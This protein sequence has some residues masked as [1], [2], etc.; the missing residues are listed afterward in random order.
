MNTETPNILLFLKIWRTTG[1]ILGDATETLSGPKLESDTEISDGAVRDR[2]YYIRDFINISEVKYRFEQ[3]FSQ[4]AATPINVLL[5]NSQKVRP[6]LDIYGQY[7]TFGAPGGIFSDIYDEDYYYELRLY[8]KQSWVN[9][10]HPLADSSTI[11]ADTF[12]STIFVDVES[13]DGRVVSSVPENYLAIWGGFIDGNTFEVQ[14]LKSTVSFTARPYSWMLTQYEFDALRYQSRSISEILYRLPVAERIGEGGLFD[15]DFSPEEN[16]ILR[17]Y[18]IPS[19]YTPYSVVVDGT[20][21]AFWPQDVETFSDRYVV[22]T[23]EGTFIGRP[24]ELGTGFSDYDGVSITYPAPPLQPMDQ[25]FKDLKRA[26]AAWS[27]FGIVEKLPPYKPN[28]LYEPDDSARC[29]SIDAKVLWTRRDEDSANV[30]VAV[31][32]Q[33]TQEGEAFYSEANWSGDGYVEDLSSRALIFRRTNFVNISPGE[34]AWA[35]RKYAVISEGVLGLDS[36]EHIISNPNSNV[37]LNQFRRTPR[38]YES[39][40]CTVNILQLYRNR[41]DGVISETDIGREEIAYLG[42]IKDDVQGDLYFTGLIDDAGVVFGDEDF[43]NRPEIGTTPISTFY[44]LPDHWKERIGQA[45]RMQYGGRPCW[46]LAW[47]TEVNGVNRAYID[48]LADDGTIEERFPIADNVQGDVQWCVHNAA[49]P[50]DYSNYVI[51]YACTVLY[52]NQYKTIVG[53]IDDHEVSIGGYKIPVTGVARNTNWAKALSEIAKS[54]GYVWWIRPDKKL[55]WAP[56]TFAAP[57]GGVDLETLLEL[58]SR[59]CDSYRSDSSRLKLTT[60]NYSL[61]IDGE[62]SV[63]LPA[64]PSLALLSRM[65]G[66]YALYLIGVDKASA[67][68][69]LYFTNPLNDTTLF[70]ESWTIEDLTMSISKASIKTSINLRKS[71]SSIYESWIDWLEVLI[72][73]QV[74]IYNSA[75]GRWTHE[76]AALIGSALGVGGI[77]SS[78]YVGPGNPVD[79]MLDI[80]TVLLNRTNITTIGAAESY[81]YREFYRWYSYLLTIINCVNS[82]C[83]VEEVE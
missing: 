27:G 75:D 44:E 51:G 53:E 38:D 14:F 71:L 24:D 1:R 74:L 25:G 30:R 26:T 56:R 40:S 10:E 22:Q 58:N 41:L 43:P 55:I 8:V 72:S 60:H 63:E 19:V 57:A 66:S 39:P 12:R 5:D 77:C 37:V 35:I 18:D 67:I 79:R 31:L 13:E 29:L 70:G 76:P 45:R 33:K 6:D 83:V 50:T 81:I 61:G 65:F 82:N 9:T 11:E 78:C 21:K 4:F 17:G 69:D 32:A 64:C 34:T 54:Y 48:I 47:T 49:Y 73:S 16:I 2:E 28:Y 52:G 68:L 3:D 59:T 23:N 15:L 36:Y 7:G 42:Y 20:L 80:W 46:V 62:Y